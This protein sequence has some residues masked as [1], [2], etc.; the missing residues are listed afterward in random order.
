MKISLILNTA[1]MD[2]LAEARRSQWRRKAYAARISMLEE[3]IRLATEQQWDEI[4]VAGNYKAGDGYSYVEVPPFSRSRADAL[5]QREQGA[6]HSTGD[7]LVFC[8]DDH[9]PN[10]GFVTK[11]KQYYAPRKDSLLLDSWDLLIPRRFRAVGNVELENGD[12][13]NNP[14]RNSYMGA[15]CLVMKRWLWAEV[16]WTSISTEYWDQS[17]TRIWKNAGGKLCYAD[18][19]IHYDMEA[20]E[21][22]N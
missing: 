3:T 22:E 8:H 20:E 14:K 16:P 15:H 6:R 18:D 12:H 5:I 1:C 4:I 9:R 7:V 21:D 11:L 19:L 13:R 10:M 17:M 2:P